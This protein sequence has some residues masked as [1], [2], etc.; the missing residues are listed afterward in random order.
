MIPAAIMQK[1]GLGMRSQDFLLGIVVQNGEVTH[2][3]QTAFF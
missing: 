1:T 3:V 2:D